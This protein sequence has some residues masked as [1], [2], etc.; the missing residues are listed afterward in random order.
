MYRFIAVSLF[1]S[2]RL[3]SGLELLPELVITAVCQ[4]SN[5]FGLQ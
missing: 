5:V 4:D 2:G 1:S 3:G